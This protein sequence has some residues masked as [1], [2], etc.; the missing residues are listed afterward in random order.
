MTSISENDSELS[1][2]SRDGEGSRGVPDIE[3][4]PELSFDEI[5]E[6]AGH[7]DDGAGPVSHVEPHKSVRPAYGEGTDR[8]V[9][10]HIYLLKYALRNRN[11]EALRFVRRPRCFVSLF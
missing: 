4:E 10:F 5:A 1:H 6:R 2:K 3:L 8:A 9:I 7:D 11:A